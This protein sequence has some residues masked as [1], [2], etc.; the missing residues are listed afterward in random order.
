MSPLIADSCLF[1]GPQ[2]RYT[3]D[4]E[5][6]DNCQVCLDSGSLQSTSECDMQLLKVLMLVARIGESVTS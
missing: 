4:D 3:L 6:A 1:T 5:P 2:H